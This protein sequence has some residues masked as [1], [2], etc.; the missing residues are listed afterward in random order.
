MDQEMAEWEEFLLAW[1]E[2]RGEDPLIINKLLRRRWLCLE[3]IPLSLYD[4]YDRE[5]QGL[6]NSFARQ[7]GQALRD[8][9]D[10]VFDNGIVLRRSQPHSHTKT[11]RWAVEKTE[12]A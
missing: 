7:L 9:V 4:R 5:L 12:Q 2:E 10:M 11:V 6:H 8:K 1:Y 3:V